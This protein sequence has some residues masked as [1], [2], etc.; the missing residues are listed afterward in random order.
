MSAAPSPDPDTAQAAA[1]GV[2]TH[3]LPGSIATAHEGGALGR[4]IVTPE[5]VLLPVQ[6]A[7]RG[8]R[9]VALIIDL[10]IILAVYLGLWLL[11]A[12]VIA[13]LIASG[14]GNDGVRIVSAIFRILS[15]FIF[16]FYFAFFE[17]RW[18]GQTPAKRMFGLRVIDRRGGPLRADAVFARNLIR[19][20]EL[21]MPLRII[22]VLSLGFGSWEML[23]ILGWLLIFMCLP[24]F[25]RDAM[26]GGDMIAGTWVI[27]LPKGELK[28]D[29]VEAPAVGAAQ[30]GAPSAG[31]ARSADEALAEEGPRYSFTAD[32]LDAYG[33]YEL[34]TLEDVLRR[35]DLNAA[36]LRDEVAKR[37]MAKIGWS[38]EDAENVDIRRFLSDFYAA[39]RAKL[40]R[41]MLFGIRR[42]D[43]HDKR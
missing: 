12:F 39:L 9:A 38:E 43:K 42:R 35:D 2:G 6:L 23:V 3:A 27:R 32:Q 13:P 29:L 40:E 34:Q 21:F 31:Q 5:G 10:L 18:Q 20:V 28:A 7:P 4:S 36:V 11:A 37:I 25:N 8:E 15:F 17:L 1:R 22:F 26:R 14:F 30:S 33:I 16:S 41:K 19:E 24:I